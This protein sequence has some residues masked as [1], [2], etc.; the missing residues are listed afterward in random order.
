MRWAWASFGQ[1]SFFVCFLPC[2]RSYRRGFFRRLYLLWSHKKNLFRTPFPCQ[3][4]LWDSSAKIKYEAPSCFSPDLWL[5][6]WTMWNCT[7]TRTMGGE[8]LL[9]LVV[10]IYFYILFS[11]SSSS[12][13]YM[14]AILTWVIESTSFC[15]F[16]QI[17]KARNVWNSGTLNKIRACS[18]ML[19]K[20]VHKGVV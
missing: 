1:C 13:N 12:L 15:Y 10:W 5:E 11:S 19:C 7:W 9:F 6:F 4:E 16:L 8:F 2:L 20:I 17:S 14:Y 18:I 3:C